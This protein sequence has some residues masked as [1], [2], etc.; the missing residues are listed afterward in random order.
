[1]K[2]SIAIAAYNE[3]KYIG[4]CLN[5]VINQKGMAGIPYE[6]VIYNDCSTD[7]TVEIAEQMLSSS[8]IPYKIY[9]ALFNGGVTRSQK[10]ALDRCKGEYLFWVDA[11]DILHPYA[12]RVCTQLLDEKPEIDYVYTDYDVIDSR[13]VNCG[14]GYRCS[15]PY[16]PMRLLVENIILH[17]K[18]I[19]RGFYHKLGGLNTSYY[20]AGDYDFNLRASEE[21]KVVKFSKT[22]YYYRQSITSV[23]RSKTIELFDEAERMVTEAMKRRGLEDK[24][25]LVPHRDTCELELVPI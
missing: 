19:R 8:G 25:R 16:D 10:E 24:Y 20:L 2:A 22:L 5:S 9:H 23:T 15:I 6:V 21:G 12:L 18:V 7:H 3:E 4:Y 17:L 14:K 11:D 1:M 13:N